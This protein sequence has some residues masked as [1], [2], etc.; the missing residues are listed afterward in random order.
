VSDSWRT[1]SRL[2]PADF[3]AGWLQQSQRNEIEVNNTP[4][5]ARGRELRWIETVHDYAVAMMIGPQVGFPTQGTNLLKVRIP[6]G[7]HTGKHCHGEEAIHVLRGSGFIVVEGRR[8]E[9]R[10]GTTIHVPF[11]AEHQLFNT[12]SEEVELVA[13]S[14]MDLDLFGRLGRLEQLEPKGANEPGFE[15]AFPS[16]DGQFDAEGRRIA[17]HLEDAPDEQKRREEAKREREAAAAAAGNGHA[18]EGHGHGHGGGHGHK[19]NENP[20]AVLYHGPARIADVGR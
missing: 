5:V 12:G 9:F 19:T 10:P 8:Y 1:V 18:H 17:L 15:S 3:Y 11:N 16:E 4:V 13:A 14:A 20:H 2:E 7:H 6:A